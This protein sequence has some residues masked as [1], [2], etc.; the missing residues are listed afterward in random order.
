[1]GLKNQSTKLPSTSTYYTLRSLISYTQS[2]TKKKKCYTQ[3]AGDLLDDWIEGFART[4]RETK[5]LIAECP[6]ESGSVWSSLNP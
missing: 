5:N 1:M 4:L 3:S 2:N 6:G